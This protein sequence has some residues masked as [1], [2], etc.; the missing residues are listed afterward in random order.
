MPLGD[1]ITL[2]VGSNTR[3]GYRPALAKQLGED[4]KDVKFVG[5]QVD[6]DGT[7]H[8]GHSGWRIDQLQ[9]NIE[10]WLAD[11]KPNV[12]LLH[13]GT[14]DMNRNYQV[15]TAPQRLGK[16]IDQ[17]HDASPD[18]AVV[19][20]SLVPATDPTVQ[21]R[22]NTYNKAIPKIVADRAQQ[23]YPISQVSMDALTTADLNDNLHPNNRGYAKMTSAFLGG[24]VGTAGKG[25]IK[26]EVNVKPAPP[27]QSTTAGDYNVDINGDG[28]ADYLVVD[29]N[30]A[31]RAWLNTG[32]AKWSAQGYIS[33]GSSNWTGGQVR[34]ADVGGDKRADY[35]VLSANG[36]VHAFI[37]EGGDGHGGWKDAGTIATGSTNWTGA[38]V[39]FADVGG[40]AKADYLV[41]S[42]NGAT[43][44]LINT[45]T[46]DGSIKW[47]DRG[48]I[49]T[50]SDW[51]ADQ[52]RFADVGGDAKADYLIVDNNGATRALINTT[53]AEGTLKWNNRGY[54]ASGS[55]DWIGSQIRFAD[56][57]G[58]AK[59]DYLILDDNGGLTGYHNVT[60]ADG[61]PAWDSQGVIASGT[62]SPGYR[63]RI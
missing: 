37:N 63:V 34:F 27:S 42:P 2:G 23:G 10:T 47:D 56:V 32:P 11:A 61:T 58:D 45:T 62:G 5:S 31:T 54:I 19:V 16:L 40:D 52:V 1:S 12:V 21:A 53:T 59:A 38:Q 50:G 46:A 30:G 24:V 55:A 57:G 43:R 25:W 15:S 18:T 14:N 6:P 4:V 13:I 51:T 28:R 48:S 3:T 36:A 20:A 33:S 9:A 22:V 29:D 39:R 44:A 17:I 60:E 26:A 49:A 41:L 7:H 35:L 8:E